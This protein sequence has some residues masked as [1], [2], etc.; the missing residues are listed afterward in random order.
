[1]GPDDVGKKIET[2]FFLTKLGR[3]IRE[4]SAFQDDG[5]LPAEMQELL[6]KLDD[7]E[8]RLSE[9]SLPERG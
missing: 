4:A 7:V 1:M 5:E 3:G 8:T 6:A 9:E 2:V